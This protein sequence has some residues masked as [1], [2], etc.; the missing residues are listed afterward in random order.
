MTIITGISKTP[1][2]T[3][4][5]NNKALSKAGFSLAEVLVALTISTFI[6]ASALVS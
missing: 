1:E 4:M 3:R 2:G 5:N 6:L